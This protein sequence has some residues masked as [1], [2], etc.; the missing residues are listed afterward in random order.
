MRVLFITQIPRSP[1]KPEVRPFEMEAARALAKR[2]PVTVM[3]VAQDGE[4]EE[5]QAEDEGVEVVRPRMR[6]VP[7]GRLTLQA[8]AMSLAIVPWI[9]R[10]AGGGRAVLHAQFGCPAGVAAT[11]AGRRLELPVVITF[12]GSDVAEAPRHADLRVATRWALRRAARVVAVAHHLVPGLRALG[13]GETAVRVVYDGVDRTLFRPAPR[14]EACA[15]LGLDPSARRLLYAGRLVEGKGVGDL[16][17]A[18]ASLGERVHLVLAGGGG[19]AWIG[20]TIRALG[21]GARVERPG[22]VAYGAVADWMNASDVVCLPSRAEGRP[23]AALEARACLRP[24]AATDIPG[25]RE[26]LKGY[27]GARWA[28]PTDP[29]DLARS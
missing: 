15:R 23:S 12:R 18:H 29:A 21:S 4:G 2:V 27:G 6:R 17:R 19:G 8:A 16:L 1:S 3:A 9:R 24:I 25:H 7:G 22:E 11:W 14:A 5:V 28:R 10:I 26:T 20:R 13:A